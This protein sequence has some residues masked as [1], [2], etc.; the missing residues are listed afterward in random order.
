MMNIMMFSGRTEYQTTQTNR[1]RRS[2]Q[3]ERRP[4][5]RYARRQSHVVRERQIQQRERIIPEEAAAPAAAAAAAGRTSEGSGRKVD[6]EKDLI[7]LDSSHDE[8]SA[9]NTSSALIVGLS[10]S[11]QLHAR[12]FFLLFMNFCE[13]W[14]ENVWIYWCRSL[15]MK[16]PTAGRKDSCSVLLDSSES[17]L[18]KKNAEG[19]FFFL[20]FWKKIEIFLKFFFFNF[21]I[22][23][24]FWNF[25]FYFEIFWNFEKKFQFWNFF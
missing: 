5:Q 19:D 17:A 2:V 11:P 9:S 13:F 20:K 15:M 12:F 10:K 3:F 18:S 23:L 21:E 22:F 14:F 8:S 24:K 25:F 4:S 6:V 16:T 1:A 7:I